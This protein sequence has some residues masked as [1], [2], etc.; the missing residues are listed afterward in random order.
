LRIGYAVAPR[1]VVQDVH[2]VRS[3]FN[4]NSLAQI[5]ALAALE[6]REHVELSRTRNREGL[7]VLREGLS[8][9]GFRVTPSVA[10][11]VLVEVAQP[12]R[13]A[14]ERLLK[15]GVIVRPMDGYGIEHGLRVSVGT[16]QENQRVLQA[17]DRALKRS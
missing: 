5:G 13:A 1:W 10:N 15:L 9:L 8:N 16:R 4:T 14:F 17:F 7:K 2:K 6:D 11:F 3:P 12:A